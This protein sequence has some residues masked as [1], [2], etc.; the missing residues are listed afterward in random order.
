MARG[1]NKVLIIG[2][3]G[4]DPDTRY[5]PSGKAVTN[6]RVATS[7]QWKDKETGDPMERTE[8]HSVVLYDKLGEIAAEYLR[9]GSQVYLEGKLRTRKWEDKEGKDRYTTEV[10]ADQLLMLGGRG[11]GGQSDEEERSQRSS[12][13]A[14]KSTSKGGTK[15]SSRREEPAEEPEDFDDDIPF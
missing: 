3:L 4:A 11:N 10:I 6:L 8:W 9:K 14:A 13:P 12:K 2:H 15:Q 5:M 7:E 1:L